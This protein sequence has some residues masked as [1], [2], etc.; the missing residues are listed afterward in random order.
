MAYR[1]TVKIK[2]RKAAQREALLL[3]AEQL[4]RA[5]GFA[6]LTIQALAQNAGVGVGTVYRY[7]SAKDELA[8]EVFRVATQREVTAVSEAINVAG[9]VAEK[10]RHAVAVFAH[11]AMRAPRLAWA[12]IAEP[13]EP[14]V[15]TERLQYR[16]AYADEFEM[17][18]Q[19]GVEDKSLSPQNCALSAAALVGA[20]A[21]ALVGPLA[22]HDDEAL[23]IDQ[24]QQFCLRAVG[25]IRAS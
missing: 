19:R 20:M 7:F 3:A 24:L 23:V 10:L 8:A 16:Q 2:E 4:V 5:H 22:N 25:A 6:G 1:E 21:E 18:L 9:D 13:A 17:L 15:D 14:A 11:R 12:L